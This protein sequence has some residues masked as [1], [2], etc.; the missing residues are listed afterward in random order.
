MRTLPFALAAAMLA[1]CASPPPAPRVAVAFP[2]VNAGF[3]EAAPPGDCPRGWGCVSH[4]D[5]SSFRFFEA[6][7]A[8]Q[9]GARS[10]CVEPVKREPWALIIQGRF[11][12][13]LRGRRLRLSLDVK[14]DGVT[15]HGA[16]AVV[17]A[18]D[19]FGARIDSKQRLLTG[20]HDWQ[21]LVVEFDVPAKTVAVDVGGMLDGRGRLCI[22][23]ARVEVEG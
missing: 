2:L 12:E 11:D 5:P 21:T 19:G 6:P 17:T 8:P 23:N 15:G 20:T 1:A 4:A 22:D 18:H 14:L 3:E 16:G 13:A 9:G 7:G 10:L